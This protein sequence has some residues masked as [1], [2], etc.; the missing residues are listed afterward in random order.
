MNNRLK[1]A[2]DLIESHRE[3]FRQSFP[4]WLIVNFPIFQAFEREAQKVWD[5][6]RKHYSARTIMEVIRHE[7]LLSEFDGQY[8]VNDHATPDCARLYLLLHPEQKG[9]FELR[10]IEKRPAVPMDETGPVV[11]AVY[12]QIEEFV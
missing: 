5:K 12:R 3:H 2:L 7:T 4:D 8:K 11:L 10:N 6:G 1:Q 9:F